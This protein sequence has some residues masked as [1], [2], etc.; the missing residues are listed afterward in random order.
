MKSLNRN[1]VLS[2]GSFEKH[3]SKV[4]EC[5]VC[6]AKIPWPETFKNKKEKVFCGV[7][8]K[9]T[10][11]RMEYFLW[12]KGDWMRKDKEKI[13]IY[14]KLYYEKNKDKKSAYY[15]N[16]YKENRDRILAVSRAYR[17]KKKKKR[18]VK[19][20]NTKNENN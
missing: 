3:Y 5:P 15:K 12:I 18:G 11:E 14:N 2:E 9:M 6:K 19:N 17:E 1:K 13:K 10:Y 4:I 8:C 16:Y 20:A 7:M